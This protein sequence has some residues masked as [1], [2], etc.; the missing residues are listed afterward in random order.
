MSQ[1]KV[2]T[3]PFVLPLY[4]KMEQHLVAIATS[5]DRSCKVQEAAEQGLA[6]L[7]KYSIPA[8]AHH[9]Y[10]IGTSESII[11][12]FLMNEPSSDYC[13]SAPSIFTQ[14]LVWRYRRRSCG[15]ES[16]DRESGSRFSIRGR[17][18]LRN[19]NSPTPRRRS[20]DYP[21]ASLKDAILSRQCLPLSTT[22]HRHVSHN[23]FEAY[24]TGGAS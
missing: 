18:L 13:V 17:N 10:V 14:P 12:P 21:K 9:S 7:R 1:S 22:C 5:W 16:G 11:S 3:I 2:P 24:T 6:K 4:H 20:Q 19:I 15:P 23:S 8:K